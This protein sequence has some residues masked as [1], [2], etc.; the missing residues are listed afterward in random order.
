MSRELLS[1]LTG[2]G[3]EIFLEGGNIR[4]CYQK[5]GSP[6]HIAKILIDELKKNKAEVVA[7]LKASQNNGTSA[8]KTFAASPIH[9]NGRDIF[10]VKDAI[11]L[12]NME[13]HIYNND[14][15]E[16]FIDTET[17]GLSVFDN[18]LVLIQIMAGKQI[19]LIN[20]A[21]YPSDYRN[22]FFVLESREFLK[23]GP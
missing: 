7:I 5:S 13:A 15:T 14:I 9:Y 12:T 18:D 16:V 3:Y 10:L 21:A 2:I 20:I 4:Y 1:E 11:G 19:F 17:T 23:M 22:V 6:T 8:A